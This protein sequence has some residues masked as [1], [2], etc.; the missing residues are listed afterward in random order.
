MDDSIKYFLVE[1]CVPVVMRYIKENRIY[2]M[3]LLKYDT[4]VSSNSDVLINSFKSRYINQ[5]DFHIKRMSERSLT[6]QSVMELEIDFFNEKYNTF[7]CSYLEKK[8]NDCKDRYSIIIYCLYFF[9]G[10]LIEPSVKRKEC[11]NYVIEKLRI[12]K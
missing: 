1:E 7:V 6:L 9:I 5:D 12:T 8:P 3:F 2:D 4:Y 11:L 10:D